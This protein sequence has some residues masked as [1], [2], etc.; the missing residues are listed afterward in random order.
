MPTCLRRRVD[1]ACH[2][3]GIY[4]AQV[5]PLNAPYEKQDLPLKY[6]NQSRLLHLIRRLFHCG[7]IGCRFRGGEALLSALHHRFLYFDI[8]FAFSL[9]ELGLPSPA[10]RD[11][12]Y[13]TFPARSSDPSMKDLR[14]N[15]KCSKIP[16]IVIRLCTWVVSV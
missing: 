4:T 9:F 6:K 10:L 7:G 5:S 1:Y 12:K 14:G 16:S 8:K 15:V 3:L 11:C 13:P 2:V